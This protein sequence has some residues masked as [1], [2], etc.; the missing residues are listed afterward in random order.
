[1]SHRGKIATI[2]RADST[3]GMQHARLPSGSSDPL[4]PSFLARLAAFA[5]LFTRPTWSQVPEAARTFL[6]TGPMARFGLEVADV[7][8]RY[9][10]AF[11]EHQDASPSTA[12][13]PAMRT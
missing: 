9:G 11:R 7:F 2:Q 12:Q 6:S 13:R 5:D 10:D 4:S 3:D 8:R 1:L